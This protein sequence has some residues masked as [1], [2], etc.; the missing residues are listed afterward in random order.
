MDAHQFISTRP[1]LEEI[2]GWLL[3]RRLQGLP[4]T[5]EVLGPLE[6]YEK[7]L[8]AGKEIPAPSILERDWVYQQGRKPLFKKLKGP[9]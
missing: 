7:R 4:V 8:K 3:G 9:R 6:V 2:E 1:C 5:E